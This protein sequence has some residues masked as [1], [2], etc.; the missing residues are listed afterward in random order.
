VSHSQSTDLLGLDE[1]NLMSKRILILSSALVLMMV[2]C[3]KASSTQGSPTGTGAASSPSSTTTP[4]ASTSVAPLTYASNGVTFDYPA[5]LIDVT[6]QESFNAQTQNSNVVWSVDLGFA[7][8]ID[9][10][11]ITAYGQTGITPAN[12]AAHKTEI[13]N[14]IT[15]LFG[16]GTVSGPIDTTLG[17]LSGYEFDGSGTTSDG[18]PFTSVIVVVFNDTLEYFVNCQSTPAHS[19]EIAAACDEIR[20]TFAVS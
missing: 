7:D 19:P 13:T 18:T 9:V 17:G 12:L 2:A 10:V 5:D 14:T 11:D 20:S 6:S 3:S 1:G 8:L 16:S 4:S 15:G